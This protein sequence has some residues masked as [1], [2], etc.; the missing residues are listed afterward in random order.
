LILKKEFGANT[1]LQKLYQVYLAILVI[2]GFLWW[3]IPVVAVALSFD[4]WIML[5]M[6]VPLL[7][8]IAIVLYWI[9]RFHSSIGYVLEDDE[10]IVTK[11]VW[12]KTK[13][14]VPYNRITNIN[15]Y[16]VQFPDV[17]GWADFQYK[18]Q[19]FQG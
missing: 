17:L 1:E 19:V 8:A 16:K 3:M 11:G 5:S 10:I 7:V 13:S 14:V 4:A 6:F 15:I 2:G 18:L 12:W 9:P